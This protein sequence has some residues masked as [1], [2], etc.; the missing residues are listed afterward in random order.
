MLFV[1]YINLATR[2]VNSAWW[3]CS[4]KFEKT[5]RRKFYY[6]EF[7]QKWKKKMV[8]MPFSL[9]ALILG[10]PNHHFATIR[11]M[12]LVEW[13]VCGVYHHPVNIFLFWDA[14]WPEASRGKTQE[15]SSSFHRL[16]CDSGCIRLLPQ[17]IAD[18]WW[19]RKVAR[20][21][22]FNGGLQVILP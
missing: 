21:S 6:F 3:A 4:K 15:E 19:F 2:L 7:H 13:G 20:P 5:W 14:R 9:R 8:S 22:K 17:S 10:V 18:C 1:W 12:G 11:N 16:L